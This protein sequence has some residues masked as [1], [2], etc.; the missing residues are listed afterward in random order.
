[1]YDHQVFLFVCFF[2]FVVVVVVFT[3]FS[4]SLAFASVSS[5][6]I[7]FELILRAVSEIQSR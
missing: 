2:G 5:F 4:I 3:I 6:F 7:L 1:M